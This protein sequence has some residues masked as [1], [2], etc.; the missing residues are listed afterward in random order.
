ML[1]KY[2]ITFDLLEYFDLYPL[3]VVGIF[4]EWNSSEI[5]K[6]IMARLLR[7]FSYRSNSHFFL[8]SCRE[9][10]VTDCELLKGYINNCFPLRMGLS[11]GGLMTVREANTRSLVPLF[12]EL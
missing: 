1:L 10:I 11:V 4:E 9:A 7:I 2:Y 3:N 5:Q 8:N 12:S 6:K